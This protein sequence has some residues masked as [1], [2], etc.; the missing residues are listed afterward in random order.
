MEYHDIIYSLTLGLFDFSVI[1]PETTNFYIGLFYNLLNILDIRIYKYDKTR[2]Q[3][4]VENLL[5]SVNKQLANKESSALFLALA[6]FLEPNYNKIRE[7]PSS[8]TPKIR[9]LIVDYYIRN[10]QDLPFNLLERVNIQ[11][12][13]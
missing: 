10:P 3:K 4:M 9:D 11:S 6:H 5:R 8:E 13:V 2:S 1:K 12:G 7:K